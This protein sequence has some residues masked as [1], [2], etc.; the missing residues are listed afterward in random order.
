MHY[1]HM[2]FSR[3]S[4]LLFQREIPQYVGSKEVQLHFT[5]LFTN[6]CS[7]TCKREKDICQ[8]S[9]NVYGIVVFKTSINSATVTNKC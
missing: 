8:T 1:P 6:T 2:G 7:S 4:L 9:S 5:H 3:T